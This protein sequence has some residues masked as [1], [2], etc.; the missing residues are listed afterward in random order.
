MPKQS[1]VHRVH[2][3]ILYTLIIYNRDTPVLAKC[4]IYDA[5]D[6]PGSGL[7]K[8]HDKKKIKNHDLFDLNQI[9]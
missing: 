1:Y 5:D 7:E 6:D 8:N 3:R 2:L 4:L 9:F